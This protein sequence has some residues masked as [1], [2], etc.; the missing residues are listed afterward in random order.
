MTEFDL[1]APDLRENPFARFAALR[2]DA[3]VSQATPFGWWVVSRYADVRRVLSDAERFR[4]PP[5]R[6]WLG[7]RRFFEPTLAA[8]EPCEPEI[9]AAA[10][11]AF[12]EATILRHERGLRRLAHVAVDRLLERDSLDMIGELALSFTAASAAEICGVLPARRADFVRWI[13]DT[14]SLTGTDQSAD[15]PE[16]GELAEGVRQLVVARRQT[17]GVDV[18]SALLADARVASRSDDDVT[19]LVL[20]LV[21]EGTEVSADLIGN[22]L[23]AL[24]D[25]PELLLQARDE[26]DLLPAVIEETLRMCSPVVGVLRVAT[27]DAEVAGATIP[28]GSTVLALVSSAGRDPDQNADPDHFDTTRDHAGDLTFGAPDAPN[29]VATRARV[30]ARI[31]LETLLE[32]LPEFARADGPVSWNRSVLFRGPRVLP[33]AFVE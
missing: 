4:A 29:P 19:A 6:P 10:A 20:H 33:V 8:P 26:P 22:A 14:L 5:A 7:E 15:Q 16:L 13:A 28:A 2:Q 32:R 21:L 17:P 12:G 24:T 23:L 11:E 25:H 3:P 9:R 27:Q 1:L 31:A 18:I 30:E